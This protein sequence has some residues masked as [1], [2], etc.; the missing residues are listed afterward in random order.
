MHETRTRSPGFSAFTPDATDSTVPTASCPSIR[1]SV[2][3]GT[4]LVA[5]VPLC[6]LRAVTAV[7]A[8]TAGA[9]ARR[10][11]GKRRALLVGLAV[12]VSAA[13]PPIL[14]QGA[15]AGGAVPI[16]HVLSNRAD[17]ISGGDALVTVE[18]PDPA[19]AVSARVSLAGAD[20]T[21]AFARRANGRFEGVVTGLALGPNELAVTLPDG[22]G[23]RI[24]ITN[25]PNGGPVFSGPQVQ[26]WTCQAGALDAQC[27]QP[28]VYSYL[29]KSSD[30][31]KTE[32]MAYDPSNPPSDVAS[33][34]TDG[35]VTVPFIV[36]LETGYQDRDQYKILTLFQPGHGW[37]PWEPQPQWNHK[38][39]VT[40]GGGCGASYGSGT[41]PLDDYSG[42]LPASPAYTQSYVTALGRGFAVMSTALDNNGHNCNLAVQAESLIMAKERLI[43]QYGEVRYTIGTGCSGGSITQQQ[44][45]NAYPGAVYDGLVVTCAYPD[46]LSTGAQFADYHMLRLY[47]EDPSKWGTGIV[48]TPAQWAAVEGRPDPLNAIV[49]DEAFFKSATNPIG[50]CVPANARYDPSTNPQGVRCSVLDYMINVLGP[51]PQTDWTPMEKAAGHGFAGVPF[52]NVGVQYGLDAL[53]KGLITPAQF[54][55]LNA[56]VGG[57]DLDANPSPTRITGDSA[58]IANAYRS[59][60]INEANNL[61]GVA[62]IDHAGPDPGAAH[63]YAHTWWMRERL[64][65]SQG[66]YRNHVLWW[67]PAPLIGDPSW[68]TEAFMA[69]DR[70]LAAIEADPSNKPRAEKVLDDKP[71][72]VVDRCKYVPGLG[73][74]AVD[75]ACPPPVVQTRY[76][77]PRSVAGD[78]ATSDVA[79]CR[80][81][82]LERS[83]YPL[84]LT[85]GQWAALQAVFPNGVCDW[86]QPGVGQQPTVP[87]LTYQ[88]AAGNVVYGGT[89]LGPPPT[90]SS[91]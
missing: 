39:L 9:A 59:G 89:P 41:A 73:A 85:P 15:R 90:S 45:A 80:L 67:G 50:D 75:D 24:T 60:G 40:H 78:A 48:W 91:L 66:H 35:G 87:W 42:T 86:S 4:A 46:D 70:W 81:R 57:L 38:V 29:Y 27:N 54:V 17:L 37:S 56:K 25:H 6:N 83:D 84:A 34:T 44:V 69:M 10:E 74:P 31:T 52:G 72:D 7:T 71:A 47:F 43:E 21:A 33:T 5:N 12:V 3:A 53:R 77:T 2:T 65:R 76:G 19:D 26:P 58:S 88:D 18:F 51:R 20:V 30:P 82:P 64:A 8:V 14:G 13:V 62:I 16:I 79:A 11:R 1:P 22:R 36:R 49:A 23:A 55:D 61:S 63:D 32:L 68:A 28:A